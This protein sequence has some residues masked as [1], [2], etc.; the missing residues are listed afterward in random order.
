MGAIPQI[1]SMQTAAM[2][3]TMGANPSPAPMGAPGSLPNFT[4]PGQPTY[5]DPMVSLN[6]GATTFGPIQPQVP[7][8]PSM[9]PGG[10]NMG[11]TMAPDTFSAASPT[12]MQPFPQMP[13]PAPFSPAGA[14]SFCGHAPGCGCGAAPTPPGGFN[15][16]A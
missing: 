5:A 14:T 1:S 8:V 6:L 9:L 13:I 2:F 4:L 15:R 12:V 7:P 11:A 10:F 3:P 16:L